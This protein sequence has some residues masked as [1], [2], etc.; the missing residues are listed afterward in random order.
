MVVSEVR[1]RSE[2]EWGDRRRLR[3]G[4]DKMKG[5]EG[6]WASR[7]YVPGCSEAIP[8]SLSLNS[9]PPTETALTSGPQVWRSGWLLIA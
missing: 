3:L 5:K 1:E 7:R 4:M 8:K 6:F 9:Y 2:A